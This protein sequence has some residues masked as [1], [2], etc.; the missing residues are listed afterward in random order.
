VGVPYSPIIDAP[1]IHPVT[2][3]HGF[4]R[5]MVAPLE[6][7]WFALHLPRRIDD[8]LDLPL[9]L[10]H[11]S[12][13]FDLARSI[14]K[15]P[16]AAP[17]LRATVANPFGGSAGARSAPVTLLE[18]AE[19]FAREAGVRL[20]ALSLDALAKAQLRPLWRKI[21]RFFDGTMPRRIV[22]IPALAPR[23]RALQPRRYPCRRPSRPLR[24]EKQQVA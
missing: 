8:T 11:D 22:P 21:S 20:G 4:D 9:Q 19:R 6:A 23:G 3:P 14:T 2:Q 17:H 5:E 15:L 12:P 10:L 13:K 18:S 1:S 24:Q 16:G 7:L